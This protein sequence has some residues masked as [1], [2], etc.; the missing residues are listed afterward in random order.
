MCGIVGV[1]EFTSP[2]AD[3]GLVRAMTDTIV[4]RGPDGEG[5]TV[6]GPVGLGHR[7]LAIIDVA[8]SPQPMTSA[9]G[10][11]TIVFNGEILNY[12]RLRDSM[13]VEWRTHGDT[14]VLLELLAGR[15]VAAL[16]ELRGQ[17]AFGLLD[18]RDGSV[19][20]ARD[21]LGILPLFHATTAERFAFASEAKALVP[22]TG[23][24]AV[25]HASLPDYLVQ[26][27][28]PSPHTLIDGV[29]K[30]APGSWMRVWPDGRT[31]SGTYWSLR[32][33]RPPVTITPA[34]A[35]DRLGE[36][37]RDAVD[38][39]LVADVPVGAYLSGGVDSSI[40]VALTAQAAKAGRLATFA[41]TFPGSAHD[42][43]AYARRVSERYGT[44]HHEIPIDPEQ[45]HDDLWRLTRYREFPI[46]EASDVAVA[47]LAALASQHVKVVLS[48]EGSD[49]LFGGYPK[50]RFAGTAEMVGK[51][52]ARLRQR[53]L[54]LVRTT[55]FA[56]NDRVSSALRAFEGAGQHDRLRSW[57]SPYS[58]REIA[59]LCPGPGRT[60]PPT[61]VPGDDPVAAMSR[62]DL[63]S[64]LSDNLLER[65]DRMTMASSIEL[66]PPF[67]D[68]R[69]VEFALAL[70][71]AIKLHDRTPKW[72]VRELARRYIDAD[73]IDRP[74]I[75]F[76]V[77]VGEWFRGRLRP[78]V[79]DL[80]LSGSSHCRQWLDAP[81]I[82]ELVR[83]HLSGAADRA[84]QLWPL[85]SLEV[86]ARTVLDAT[87]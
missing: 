31:E 50:Y 3:L 49:E 14:E 74:K 56:K 55:A 9:D 52:P 32:T 69:V 13:D 72:P 59:R 53:P 42:E 85:V 78:E 65:G 43:S 60:T 80:L 37:L 46:S 7:R 1:V 45:F 51:L 48:G 12:R 30:L 2:Q 70:P 36:L 87:P 17:F 62:N 29:S 4:H 21:R 81:Y 28:V 38:D 40:I 71:S 8:G 6:E 10:R 83:E 47:S 27:A 54:E 24:A 23:P 33:A 77:P 25:D 16:P 44:D 73:L 64:W 57:F 76:R 41:A 75:G 79:E 66:R 34:A 11:C 61:L 19:L 86:W 82:D 39:A 58:E 20:L 67:L 18:H 22:A 68:A 35:V 26:R 84:K 15:G 5:H 63:G